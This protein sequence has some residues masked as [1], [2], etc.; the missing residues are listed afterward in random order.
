MKKLILI[1]ILLFSGCSMIPYELTQYQDI[2]PIYIL[3]EYNPSFDTELWER[4]RFFEEK[5][6]CWTYR[7]MPTYLQNMY[8]KE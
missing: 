8:E 2:C 4:Q 1:L 7:I 3:K 6:D 5:I